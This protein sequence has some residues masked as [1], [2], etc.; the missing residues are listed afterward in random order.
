[1]RLLLSLLLTCNVALAAGPIWRHKAKTNVPPGK[2]AEMV[3]SPQN[4]VYNVK[5]VLSTEGMTK[6]FRAKKIKAGAQKRFT[7]KPPK[8]ISEWE[9]Q[10][11]G[12]ADGATTTAKINLRIVSVGPLK[13]QIKPKDVD[14]INGQILTHPSRPLSKVELIA[15]GQKGDKIV[16]EEIIPEVSERGTIF[17]FEVPE[18]ATIRMIQMKM[19]DE[20][21]FWSAVN[22][23]AWYI[24]VA[25]EEVQFESGSAEIRPE[26][27]PKLDHAIERIEGELKALKKQLAAYEQALKQKIKVEQRLF[28]GGYTDTVGQPKDNRAL[29][30]KRAQSIAKYFKKRLPIPI[31]YDGFGEAALAVP[32]E[33]E[34]DEARNRRVLYVLSNSSPAGEGFPHASWKKL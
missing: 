18:G 26:E 17:R 10:L 13:V 12:S 14:L 9:G 19:H 29:S 24:E 25:H 4:T 2:R 34:V 27:R 6:T 31:Y 32:T 20:H 11:T 7:W 16:D 30:L 15:F 28:V 5:L 8:G 1:M 3:L 23:A 22:I 21:S 33:N